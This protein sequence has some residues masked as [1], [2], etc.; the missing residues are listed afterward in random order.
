MKSLSS[1]TG[2]KFHRCCEESNAQ[3][4]IHRLL[5]D[6]CVDEDVG[7]VGAIIS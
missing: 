1:L 3:L 7:K 2:G 5:E 6:C 4:A